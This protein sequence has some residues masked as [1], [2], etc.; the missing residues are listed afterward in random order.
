MAAIAEDLIAR[1]VTSA[2]RLGVRGGSNGGLLTGVMLTQRPDLWGAVVVQVPLL[3]MKRFS[4]LLAGASWMDEYG[5][6]DTQDWEYI[7]RYS[8]YHNI[9][10]DADYPKAFF[11]TS[12]RDDRVHPAHARKMVAR[13]KEFGHDLYYYENTVGGHAGASDN[14]Q[15]ARLEALIYSYLWDQ[16]GD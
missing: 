9:D 7:K 13:M 8:P 16:L 12:T 1:E 10:E 3:D 4:Q 14:T 6:P 5:D 2:G 11:T 15:A